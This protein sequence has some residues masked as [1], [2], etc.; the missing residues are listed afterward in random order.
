MVISR[1]KYGAFRLNQICPSSWVSWS[2]Y[3]IGVALAFSPQMALD[4]NNAGSGA[5]ILG[6]SILLFFVSASLIQRHMNLSLC[7]SSYG[8]PKLLTTN[9]VFAF[10]R[11]P[12]YVAFLL[13]LLSMGYYSI[14]AAVV[15]SAIYIWAMTVFIIRNEEAVLHDKFGAVYGRY[16]AATPRWLFF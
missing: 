12:I 6:A 10:S 3:A 11:N 15:A 4:L 13:P 2:S 1:P 14:A 5:V 7:S 8:Q 16:V 9:G